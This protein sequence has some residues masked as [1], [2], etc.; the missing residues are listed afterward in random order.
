LNEE[1]TY[2][3][4]NTIL[5]EECRQGKN[6]AFRQ[7]YDLYSEAMY[8]ICCRM[9]NDKEE[10]KDVLQESFISA[11]R[12]IDQYNGKASFGSWLK[13]I[14]INACIATIKKRNHDLIPLEE[15]DLPEEPI[16]EETKIAFTVEEIKTAISK[17][18][19]GYRIILSLYLFEDHS[20]KMIAEKLNISEGTSKSQYS[21]ARRKLM[22][23]I[24][25]SV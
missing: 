17:L 10:A 8:T 6:E 22:E 9:L 1:L 14:V 7:V 21:R 24:K 18:P 23:M 25:K 13:R 12:N 5:I 20:H 11:F 4:P 16:E 19:D 3:E 15:R 2:T